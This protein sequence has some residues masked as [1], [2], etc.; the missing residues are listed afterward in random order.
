MKD[1]IIEIKKGIKVHLLNT[2]KFKTNLISVFLTTPVTRENATYNSVLSAVL[3]RGSKN[4]PTQE[5][6]SEKLEELYG[7]SF[8]CGIDKTG[9]NHILKYYLESINGEYISNDNDI[10]KIS[11]DTLFEIIF[12]PYTE[13]GLFKKEYIDQE[14]DYVRQLIEGK[15]DNKAR[16]AYDRCIEEM[17]KGTPFGIYKYG[18]IELLKH[19]NEE[20]LYQYYINLI[21]NCKIDIFLS[22][23]F[24]ENVI[25]LISKNENIFNLKE[26]NPQYCEYKLEKKEPVETKSI[27]E[28]MNITQGKLVIGLDICG[29]KDRRYEAVVYNAILGGTANSKMF[30]NVREKASL[31]YTASSSFLRVKNNMFINCGIE[32][33]NYE[34]ALSII[35]EQLEDMQTGKFDEKDIDNAKKSIISG[36]YAIEDEQ[37]TQISYFFGQELLNSDISIEEYIEKIQAVKKEDIIDIAK[38]ININTIYFLKD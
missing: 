1:K 15:I 33:A 21:N 4:L 31:A 7:S 5:E 11:I 35:K 30:Q 24:D 13:K 23:D 17:Y 6:I 27:Q 18:E 37:D 32:I 19:I 28:S 10:L 38:N 12:N 9:D 34:K 16:Y 14:K 36:V 22:G 8:D 25:E 2:N 29:E 20:N 3:R 26:R